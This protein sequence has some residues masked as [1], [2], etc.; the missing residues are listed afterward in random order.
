MQL[1]PTDNA[2]RRREALKAVALWTSSSLA[3]VNMLTSYDTLV[4]VV[5]D[6]IKG[7]LASVNAEE[8]IAL[9]HT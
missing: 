2:V 9:R 7:A 5:L 3:K 4:Q 6:E 8:L 1:L